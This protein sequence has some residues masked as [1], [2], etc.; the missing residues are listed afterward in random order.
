MEIVT[1]SRSTLRI[2]AKIAFRLKYYYRAILNECI[3]TLN[4]HNMIYIN[5]SSIIKKIFVFKIGHF[6]K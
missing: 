4:I 1:E 3:I 6:L 5:L 2:E